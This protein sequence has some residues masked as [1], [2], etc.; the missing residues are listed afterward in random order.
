MLQLQSLLPHKVSVDVLLK[1]GTPLSASHKWPKQ[2][3]TEL[4]ICN[5]SVHTKSCSQA[6][7]ILATT[8]DD[9]CCVPAED[10]T[11]SPSLDGL[12]QVCMQDL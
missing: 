6:Q 12:Q 11:S 8:V 3:G 1:V 2:F 9:L 4:L 7:S 10:G 5:V